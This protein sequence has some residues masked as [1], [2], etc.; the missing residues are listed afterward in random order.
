M[1]TFDSN[2][3]AINYVVEG[4]GPTIVLIHGFTSSLQGNWRGPGIIDAIVSA[5][6]QVVALD[7]R[8]HGESGKPQDPAA[9]G[10]SAMADD[11]I[12]LMDHLGI[13]Q[14]D[15]MGYSMGGFISAGLLVRYPERFRSVVLAG[16]GDALVLSGYRP[17]RGAVMAEAMESPEGGEVEDKTARG[18]RIFAERTGND[19]A[20]M[21]RAPSRATYDPTKLADVTVPVMVLIGEG[22]VLVG[23]ADQL[24]ATIP[25]AKLV[26]V[27]G[28]HL[29]AV[30]QPLLKKAVLDFLTEHSCV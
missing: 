8:G 17:A 13:G 11:V 19:L 10:G 1:P 4:E 26:V 5:G 15:L 28:D 3:V 16:V 7:C 25:R 27:P 29:T 6:R 18:F 14:T 21:Q 12:A 22:D 23:P 9:Y 2:G 30:G 24:A 20:A